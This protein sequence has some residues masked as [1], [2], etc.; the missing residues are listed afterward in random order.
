MLGFYIGGMVAKG[1]NFHTDLM[2]RIG[3]E[4]EAHRI[5][6]LFFEG[7]RDEAI[8]AVPSAFADEISLVGPL[9]RIKERLQV[10]KDSPVTTLTM[11]PSAPGQMEQIAKIVLAD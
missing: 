5:Q 2:A 11:Y 6:D 8:A 9:G 10:W 4:E 7:K 3:F 1:K